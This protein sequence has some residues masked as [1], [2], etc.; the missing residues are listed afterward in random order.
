MKHFDGSAWETVDT[1][2]I[3]AV[4]W[5]DVDAVSPTSVWAVGTVHGAGAPRTAAAHWDGT[6][7]DEDTFAFPAGCGAGAEP[8]IVVW[9]ASST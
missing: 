9:T 8:Q 4:A 3:G 6:S 1:A 7:W 5:S 2:A